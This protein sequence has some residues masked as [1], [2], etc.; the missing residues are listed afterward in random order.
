MQACSGQT[1]QTHFLQLACSHSTCPAL[2]CHNQPSVLPCLS[3]TICPSTCVLVFRFLL[4][5]CSHHPLFTQ[6]SFKPYRSVCFHASC[7]AIL[8]S[9]LLCL[10]SPCTLCLS[11]HFSNQHNDV[12]AQYPYS[13]V[14]TYILKQ[15]NSMCV[16]CAVYH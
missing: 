12:S 4:H 15:G 1:D 13:H 16:Q 8:G 6:S 9:S 14:S 2:S 7:I 10:I 11:C 3:F 5:C